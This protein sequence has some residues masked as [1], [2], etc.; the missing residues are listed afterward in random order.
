MDCD[1]AREKQISQIYNLNLEQ[2]RSR[3]VP[4]LFVGIDL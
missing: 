3:Q 1:E 4:T 2:A